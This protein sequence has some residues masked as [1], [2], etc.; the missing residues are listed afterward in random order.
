MS[1]VKTSIEKRHYEI[2]C[3]KL[4][5]KITN[6]AGD[7]SYPIILW[8][9]S[10]NI[11]FASYHDGEYLTRVYLFVK[12]LLV[13]INNT[14]VPAVIFNQ[15]KSHDKQKILAAYRFLRIGGV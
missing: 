5:L 11:D 8:N 6:V 15:E 9:W 14:P 1:K 2:T 7:A 10:K 12:I 3:A 13:A 4:Q